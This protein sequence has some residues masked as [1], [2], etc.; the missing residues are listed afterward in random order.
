MSYAG[1]EADRVLVQHALALL[2]RLTPQEWASPSARKGWSVQDVVTHLG[3]SSRRS[4]TRPWSCRST[5][6]ARPRA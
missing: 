3:Y 6:P 2:G 1:V 4:P 5:P